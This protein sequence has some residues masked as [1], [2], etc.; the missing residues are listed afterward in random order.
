MKAINNNKENQPPCEPSDGLNRSDDHEAG[1][2]VGEHLDLSVLNMNTFLD[3]VT[4]TNDDTEVERSCSGDIAFIGRVD[5]ASADVFCQIGDGRKK[6]D[7]L[8]CQI[9]K[10]LNYRFIKYEY[11]HELGTR[12]TYSC[13]QSSSRKAKSQ[14]NDNTKQRDKLPMDFF[15]C[16]GWLYI[17]IHN[18]DNIALV[19]LRHRE[20]HI[21]YWSIDVPEEIKKMVADNP[22]LN[23]TQLWSEVLKV[24]PQ[25][26]FSRTAIYRLWLNHQCQKWKRDSDELKSAMAVL[27]EA[28]QSPER[29]TQA[30]PI[31]LPDIEGYKAIAF[32]LP[33]I[34]RQWGSHIREISLDSAW[35]TNKS[36]YEVYAILGEVYGSGCPLGYLLVTS[37]GGGLPGAKENYLSKV[38]LH[39]KNHWQLVPAFTHTDKDL[40]EINACRKIFPDAKHQL[41]FWHC[42][43]AIRTR[44]S[45]LRRRPKPYNVVEAVKEFDWID[46]LFVPASQ[47]LAGNQIQALDRAVPE[48]KIRLGGTLQNRAPEPPLFLPSQQL[49][50]RLHNR[51]QAVRAL[52]NDMSWNNIEHQE[53]ET[54]NEDDENFTDTIANEVD[55]WYEKEGGDR[56][57]EDGPDWMFDTGEVTS[58][59]P[60]YVFCPAAHRRTLL[61]LFTKHF[62]QHPIFDEV[63]G[64]WDSKKI[65]REAIWEMYN[66]CQRRGL[67]EVWGY[68]WAS[69]YSPAMWKLWARSTSPL[70]SRLRTTMSVE[71]FWRQLKHDF[72]HRFVHPRLDTLTWILIYE[73]TPSYFA[74][75]DILDDTYRWGRSKSLSNYQKYFKKSWK[76][77]ELATISGRKTHRTSVQEWTCTCGRQKFDRHHLCKHLVRAVPPPGANFFLE[78]VRRRTKPIYKHPKLVS[79]IGEPPNEDCI[80]DTERLDSGSITDGDDHTWLGEKSALSGGGGWKSAQKRKKPTDA[81]DTHPRK[82][83]ATSNVETSHSIPIIDLT[84]TSEGADSDEEEEIDRHVDRA[85][86]LAKIFRRASEIFTEQAKSR[87]AL[88]LR[89]ISH[90]GIGN[91]LEQL[92]KDIERVEGSARKRDTTWGLAEGRQGRQRV[93]NTMGYIVPT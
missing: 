68:M 8:A 64:P 30:E 45:I 37:T 89:S 23:V 79:R 33:D 74:K 80:H 17:T 75:I 63:D 43:R 50:I 60:A 3:A 67:A 41:C 4:L 35:N 25:P 34:I 2:G 57:E 55:N 46:P 38:L 51:V 11:K 6:A 40:S 19:K 32:S 91:D 16:E 84:G 62:C 92:V 87:S 7:M 52:P 21:P 49:V 86:H 93:A 78:I 65:R 42:L 5:L 77:L 83:N 27:M 15:N 1:L 53:E 58:K 26:H 59:D 54:D 29:F 81:E 12:F 82:K 72:L 13:S 85:L 9:W 76:K 20:A 10:R 70:L 39:L 90:R 18:S 14:K 31:P 56:D 69:W 28:Q 22:L 88:W 73:V 66:F 44:L 24:I 61:H 48:L 36:N 71:N 47:Q